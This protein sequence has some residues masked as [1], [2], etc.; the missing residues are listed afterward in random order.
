MIANGAL[1]FFRSHHQFSE[2]PAAEKL[3]VQASF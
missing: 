2:T 1:T 3:E